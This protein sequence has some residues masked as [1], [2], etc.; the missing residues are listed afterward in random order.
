MEQSTN[1]DKKPSLIT[2]V[3]AWFMVAMVLANTAGSARG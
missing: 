3:L 1:T 2:P